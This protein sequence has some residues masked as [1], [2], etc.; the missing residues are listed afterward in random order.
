MHF[1]Y[2]KPVYF[3]LSVHRNM[4]SFIIVSREEGLFEHFSGGKVKI[5]FPQ[6]VAVN[7][8]KQKHRESSYIRNKIATRKVKISLNICHFSQSNDAHFNPSIYIQGI[9]VLLFPLGDSS[10]HRV[11]HLWVKIMSVHAKDIFD[12][13]HLLGWDKG[14]SLL[15]C[16]V[17]SVLTMVPRILTGLTK[18]RLTLK[19]FGS[20]IT[21]LN[22]TVSEFILVS[23]KQIRFRIDHVL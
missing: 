16:Q 21:S 3:S 5:F 15:F 1:N 22:F 14:N 9:S 10:Y 17:N 13:T 20:K 19:L 18:N 6:K 8:S 7:I 23:A 2:I 11:V 12:F 4:F